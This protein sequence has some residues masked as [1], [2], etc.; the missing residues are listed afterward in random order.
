M[1]NFKGPGQGS[2]V[3]KFKFIVYKHI[4]KILK[5]NDIIQYIVRNHNINACELCVCVSA[6]CSC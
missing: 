3:F 6:N 5:M 4:L 2:N 1:R